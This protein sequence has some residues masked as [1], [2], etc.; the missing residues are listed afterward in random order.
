MASSQNEQ[1]NRHYARA[2]ALPMLEPTDSQQAYDFT[3]LAFEISERW[4]IPVILRLTT[5][6][7]HAKT[8]VR[9][10]AADPRSYPTPDFERNIPARVM[11]P[12]YAKPAHQ[13][14][15]QK[16]AEIAAWN[17]TEGPIRLDAAIPGSASSPPASP[18]CMPARPHPRPAI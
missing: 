8:V 3:W 14:L 11:I 7:C 6:V 18:P 5:R 10:R 4:K 17:E 9:P 12:A 13:R 2:A 16:L 1:D 15:R